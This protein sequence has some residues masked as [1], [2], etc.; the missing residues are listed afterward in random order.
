MQEIATVLAQLDQVAA[1]L[2]ALA[3]PIELRVVQ[4]PAEAIWAFQLRYQAIVDR[5]WM[6]PEEFPGGLERDH[7]DDDAVQILGWDG[8]R[9]VATARVALPTQGRRLPVE[10]AFEL[11][12]EPQGQV[13]DWGRFVV[14]RAYSGNQHRLY[15]ALLGQC[16]MES[17]ARGYS[18]VCGNASAAMIRLLK[19]A[20]GVEVSQ[21]GPAR[22]HWGEARCPF[23][24]D[25]LVTGHKVLAQSRETTLD[26]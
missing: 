2:V 6:R 14:A 13:A 10:E 25:Y 24:F 1:K 22:I 15:A 18:Q 19:R 17:R 7:Y 23:R 9:A 11:N 8:T 3:A 12:V 4:E 21:I 16:W 26:V 5:G 20:A